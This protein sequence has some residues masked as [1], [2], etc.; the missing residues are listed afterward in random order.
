[1]IPNPVLQSEPDRKEKANHL[2]GVAQPLQKL[3]RWVKL[4]LK[5][6][7]ETFLSDV[8]KLEGLGPP[9]GGL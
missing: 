6:M 4:E 5:G 7:K 3:L 8:H 1:M 9:Q 2:M